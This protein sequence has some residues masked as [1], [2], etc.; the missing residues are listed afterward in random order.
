MFR[1]LKKGFYCD[2]KLL[3]KVKKVKEFKKLIVIK[4]WSCRSIIMLDFV[5]FK[6]GIYNGKIYVEVLIIGDMVGYKF[7]E[8]FLIK[9][10]KIKYGGKKVK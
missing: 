6:F 3:V 1:F 10:F 4:I 9:K 5:G 7:G 8:F 2:F